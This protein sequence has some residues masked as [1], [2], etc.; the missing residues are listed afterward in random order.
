MKL[1]TLVTN[2]YAADDDEAEPTPVVLGVMKTL[3]EA[4][5]GSGTKVVWEQIS[6]VHW[7]T[8]YGNWHVYES[9]VGK[10]SDPIE[11]YETPDP[12]DEALDT[13]IRRCELI[14][15]KTNDD[16]RQQVKAALDTL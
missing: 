7:Q 6:K 10:L 5:R 9:K 15:L 14:G 4:Q 13:F 12:K 16:F 11:E 1:F 2:V 8:T 3:D